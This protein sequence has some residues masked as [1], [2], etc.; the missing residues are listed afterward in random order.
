MSTEFMVLKSHDGSNCHCERSEAIH[1][2]ARKQ[3]WIASSHE[4]LAMTGVIRYSFAFSPRLAP[5]FV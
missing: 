3:E 2:A 4:L 5:E 1:A